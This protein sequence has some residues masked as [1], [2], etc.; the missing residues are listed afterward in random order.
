MTSE[1][2]S[3][4]S[5]LLMDIKPGYMLGAKP[6]QQAWG[7]VIGV[8][9]GG[10]ASTLLFFPLFLP[11]HDPT[12][13]LGP[14]LMTEKFPM[15]G[16]DIW[17]GVAQLIADGGHSLAGSAIVAMSFAALAG[18]LLEVARLKTKNKFPLSAVAIGLGAVLPVDSTLIMVAGAH[19]F[20]WLERRYKSAPGSAGHSLWVESQEPIAAGIVAGAALMGIGDQLIS[21]FVL[22]S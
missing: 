11:H 1:V 10:I 20:A 18:V 8:V 17:R 5:N 14:Q 3:N 7:H 12:Q 13:P 9:S 19:F 4:A 15:P 22:G 6:R 21:V 16:V 2:A